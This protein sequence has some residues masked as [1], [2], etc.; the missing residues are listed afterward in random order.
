MDNNRLTVFKNFYEAVRNCS[1]KAKGE[2]FQALCEH[3]FYG[4]ETEISDPIAAAVYTV[5]SPIIDKD[6]A[7]RANGAKGAAFGAKGGR[8]KKVV[9]EQAD[10]TDQPVDDTPEAIEPTPEPIPEPEQPKTQ[11]KPAKTRQS[12]KTS[13]VDEE[14]MPFNDVISTIKK[15][16]NWI[17]T[18]CMRYNLSVIDLMKRLD[19]FK[20]HCE[21][22][23][24]QHGTVQAAVEHFNSWLPKQQQ[25]KPR[26]QHSA[27]PPIPIDSPGSDDF[28][29]EIY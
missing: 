15:D 6:N 2:L 19:E 10:T 11:P 1:I 16:D 17:E 18:M 24:K 5:T 29:G 8:P 9:T 23:K 22:S 27:T 25:D 28:G 12:K 21:C 26:K 7:N 3:V 14:T 20:V 13:P 4:N